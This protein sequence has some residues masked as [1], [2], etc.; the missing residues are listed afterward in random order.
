MNKKLY[1]D[2][3]EKFGTSRREFEPGDTSIDA[4]R[5]R[6]Y[7]RAQGCEPFVFDEVMSNV[8]KP[9]NEPFI[10][11][12][13]VE[14][15]DKLYCFHVVG[16]P[17]MMG[18]TDPRITKLAYEW[19]GLAVGSN[20]TDLHY[21]GRIFD[22]VLGDWNAIATG[23]CPHVVPFRDRYAAVYY[24][25]GMSGTRLC[26][27]FSDDL[28]H[29][30]Q[31]PENPRLAPPPWAKEHGTCKDPH[32]LPLDDGSYLVYF[33]VSP[34]DGGG[35][36][37]VASTRDFV[38][39]EHHEKPVIVMP[40]FIR[41]TGG[42]ESPCVVERSGIYHLF[43]CGGEGLMHMISDDPVNWDASR[44]IYRVGPF[45]A[46]EIF[47]WRGEWW[48][49][50]TKKEE[51]RRQDRLKGISHHGDYED[52]LRN[53]EGMFLSHINWEGDFPILEKPDPFL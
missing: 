15:E 52:E 5:Y 42:V 10:D 21:Q 9:P 46:S 4:R 34:R 27:A 37:A 28:V 36:I 8:Y 32:V 53:L 38:N 13:F 24:V 23:L 40:A 17:D 14:H 1:D 45:V 25:V 20:L 18:K 47:A 16:H 29:W 26:S 12:C 51:L 22:E 6:L 3:V 33:C 35:A 49:T 44:G 50:S 41:G 39:F 31:H 43:V 19:T 2:Y 48:L 30:E 11:H 7:R